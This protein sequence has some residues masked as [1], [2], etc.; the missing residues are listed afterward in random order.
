MLCGKW[1]TR[2]MGSGYQS[3]YGL[4]V[5]GWVLVSTTYYALPC[6]VT[7][8]ARKLSRTAV[9]VTNPTSNLQHA[10]PR[11]SLLGRCVG[12]FPTLAYLFSSQ[13]FAK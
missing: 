6:F 2:F 12:G 11:P 8:G 1:G 7:W 9:V 3:D 5:V 4:W 13:D 10:G